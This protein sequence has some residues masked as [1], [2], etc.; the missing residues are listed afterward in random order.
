MREGLEPSIVFLVVN[1][2]HRDY[3]IEIEGICTLLFG[4]LFG[5]S[6]KVIKDGGLGWQ[7]EA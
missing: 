4:D 1:S 2:N 3:T 5:E 6:R 7:K